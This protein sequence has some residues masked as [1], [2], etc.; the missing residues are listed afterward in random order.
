MRP[1]M[2]ILILVLSALLLASCS[3]DPN[4]VKARYLESGNKYFDRGRYREASIMYRNAL[5]KD[6]LFGQAHYK[7][8]LA[9]M[10]LGRVPQAVGSLRRAMERIPPTAAEHWDAAL[11]LADIYV[12][13]SRDPQLLAEARDIAGKLLAKDPDS[14]DG[15]RLTG[16]LAY[17]DARLAFGANNRQAAESLLQAAIA[18]YRKAD[19]VK[20]EQP[21]LRMALARTLGA[22]RAY[23]EAEALYRGV[24]AKDSHQV[25]AHTELYQLFLWQK[26]VNE[27]QEALKAAVAANPK[28]FGLLTLLAAHYYGLQRREEMAGVLR[29]MK[30][31]SAEFP[32]AYMMAGD[33]YLRVGDGAAALKEYQEGIEKDARRKLE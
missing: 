5:A 16:D 15:H 14:F 28:Q 26:K 6:A 22:S 31:R 23:A 17:V 7:L 12:A 24:I 27:G 18:S 10:H 8:A 30:D 33:F 3:R 11:R 4:V 9:E 21:G 29:R 1:K 32:D 19:S 13:A 2:R 25:Q 20:P